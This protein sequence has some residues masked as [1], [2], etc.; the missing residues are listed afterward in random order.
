[1]NENGS[2]LIAILLVAVIAFFLSPIRVYIPDLWAGLILELHN[3]R[4]IAIDGKEMQVRKIGAI[5][6]ELSS[7][8]TELVKP[9][10]EVLELFLRPKT[11]QDLH[12][13]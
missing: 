7:D 8:E 12:R 6:S 3:V 9:N 5:A 2:L 13:S 1:M 4:Q 10:S 11:L